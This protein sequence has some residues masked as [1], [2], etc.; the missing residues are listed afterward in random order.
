VS[1]ENTQIPDLRDDGA[2]EQAFRQYFPGLCAYAHRFVPDIETAEEVVQEVFTQLWE[3]RA[4]L[5]LKS[6]LKSYLFRSVHNR[7]LN[8]IRNEKVRVHHHQTHQTERPDASFY[9]PAIVADVKHRVY[10][11]IGRLPAQ[12]GKIFR[13]SRFEALSYKEIA[14]KLELSPKTVEV[15]MGKALKQLRLWLQDVRVWWLLIFLN[16]L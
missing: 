9:D 13:M 1:A 6:S 12:R 5:E 4:G 11:A 2:F 3:K 8:Q 14:E 16:H 7:C 15:Q 10:E